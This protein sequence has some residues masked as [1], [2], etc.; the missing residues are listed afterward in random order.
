MT[1][2]EAAE[3]LGV[4]PDADE[5]EIDH[6]YRRLARE[7]HPDRAI[8]AAPSTVQESSERFVDATLAKEVL[9]RSA[10]SR[11][12]GGGRPRADDPSGDD[13]PGYPRTGTRVRIVDEHVVDVVASVRPV[14]ASWGLFATWTLLLVIGAVLALSGLPVWQPVDLWLRVVLLAAS[15]IATGLTGRRWLWNTTLVLIA[16]N[17]VAVVLATTVG[18]LLGLGFMMVASFGLAVQARLVRFPDQ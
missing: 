14:P 15:A 8:G 2:D 4:A 11:A 5:P 3:V 1:P 13:G 17:G 9:L 10:A 18:G 6:A 16:V 12:G 7:L